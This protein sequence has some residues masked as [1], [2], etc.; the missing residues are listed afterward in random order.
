[1]IEECLVYR[2]EPRNAEDKNAVGV[3]KDGFVVGRVPKCFS[4]WM[5]M[6]L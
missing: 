6:F 5:S 1:M 2:R 3:V 4:L